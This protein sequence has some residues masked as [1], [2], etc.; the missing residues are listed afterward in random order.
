M[1][2][3]SYPKAGA[4][5][6][7]PRPAAKTSRETATFTPYFWEAYNAVV[8]PHRFDWYLI[9]RWLPTLG[10]DGFTVVKAL[11]SL[12][13]FNPKDGALRD[14]CQ[15]TVD[16]LAAKCGMTRPTLY[17]VLEK[18]EALKNFVQRLPDAVFVEGR[19]RRLPPRFRVCMDTPVHPDDMEE[20]D[21][22]RGRNEMDRAQ[23]EEEKR[24]SQIE[25]YEKRKS[26]IEGRKS[27]NGERKSQNE[28]SYNV[29]SL[30]SE[31]LLI[32]SLHGEAVPEPPI[33]PQGDEEQTPSAAEPAATLDPLAATWNVALGH[34]AEI[35]NKPTLETHLKALRVVSISEGGATVLA[36]PNKFTHGWVTARHQSDIEAALKEALGSPPAS[37]QI[38]VEGK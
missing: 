31:S 26:Q 18:N 19:T 4:A 22:L 13:Y 34:L 33:N 23:S 1:S 27:Q 20:Y 14:E 32:D 15:L 24:K 25:I 9:E 36:A 11:R 29:N 2:A 30:P 16:E 3:S 35:V 8:Q 5:V 10:P 17:R 7:A 12:C 37:V 28:I 38:I 6:N 21:R